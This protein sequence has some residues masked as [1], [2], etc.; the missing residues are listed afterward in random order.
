MNPRQF[1]GNP[2][3]MMQT[4]MNSGNPVNMLEQMAQQS[5]DPKIVQ[6]VNQAKNMANNNNINDMPNVAQNFANSIN[7]NFNDVVNTVRQWGL[8]PMPINAKQED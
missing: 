6:F 3:V 5:G 4:L 2:Q 7:A 1:F 8:P